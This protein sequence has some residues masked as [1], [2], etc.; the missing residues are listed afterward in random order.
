MDT[1]EI[2]PEKKEMA[3]SLVDL[4]KLANQTRR[5]IVRMVYAVNSGHPGASLG[6]VEFFSLCITRF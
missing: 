2:M 5:D 4:K 6:C 1:L 3:Y